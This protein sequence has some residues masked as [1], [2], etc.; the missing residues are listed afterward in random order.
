MNRKKLIAKNIARL[1]RKNATPRFFAVMSKRLEQAYG[2][3]R[4]YLPQY[5]TVCMHGN[6]PSLIASKSDYQITAMVY[7]WST[8]ERMFVD[9]FSLWCLSERDFII[10]WFLCDLSFIAEDRSLEHVYTL[11]K[12]KDFVIPQEPCRIKNQM[13]PGAARRKLKRIASNKPKALV[14]VRKPFVPKLVHPT[15]DVWI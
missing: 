7:A 13:V 9:E 10:K 12:G 14:P 1:V 3:D 11:S 5:N 2:K 15:K 8:M 6:L 4:V